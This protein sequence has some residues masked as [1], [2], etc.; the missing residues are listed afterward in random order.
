MKYLITNK[1]GCSVRLGDIVF[2]AGETKE[3]DDK[4]YSDKFIVEEIKNTNIKSHSDKFIVEKIKEE[5]KTTKFKE[6]KK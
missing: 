1:L 2:S 6:D 4:P 5:K 3:L